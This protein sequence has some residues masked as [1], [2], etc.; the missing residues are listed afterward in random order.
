[1][2][3]SN[4][5]DDRADQASAPT[6]TP[7]STPG[8]D[9][10][11]PTRIVTEAGPADSA[12]QATR[13]A[14]DPAAASSPELGAPGDPGDD[15]H[16]KM[17]GRSLG[18]YRIVAELGVGGMGAVYL[19]EQSVPVH[20]Q[21]ALKVIKAG[22]D[23]AELLQRFR[24]ERDMLARMNHPNIAQVLDV[25]S[26]AGGRLYFAMEYVPGVPLDEFADR[27][28]LD[29][30]HRLELFLQVLEGVQ[31]AH[32][33]GVMHRDLKP[34]NL[35]VADYQGQLLVKVI[36]FGI[37]KGLDAYGRAEAGATTAGLPIGTPNYMSPEQASGDPGAIDTRTDVYS[38]GVVLYKLLTGAL[39]IASSL[40]ARAMHDDLARALREAEIK[41]PSR[42]VM[43]LGRDGATQWKRQ[44]AADH[45]QQARRLRGDLD[46]ITL[47][48][49]E[50]DR[51]RRYASVSEFAAE[52]RR[53][54]NGEPVLAGPPS[55]RYR[56][57]KFIAR[58]RLAVIAA[59][60]VLVALIVGIIGTSW[61]AIEASQQRALAV[62]A[63]HQAEAARDQAKSDRDRAQATRS[64]LEE[65]IAA[66]DPWK[67]RGDSAGARDIRVADALVKAG[68]NLDTGLADNPGLR[69][70]IATL[71]GRTQR[72]LGLLESARTQLQSAVAALAPLYP[73]NAPQRIQA[74][75]EL[76]LTQ[77][78]MG[79]LK[80]AAKT[81]DRL[82]PIIDTVPGLASGSAEELRSE[83]A[84][85]AAQLG[86]TERA[87]RIAR[88]NLAQAIEGSGE[89]S[90]PVS[91]AK[92]ALAEILGSRGA[93]DEAERLL[94]EA[95]N[96]ERNRLGPAHPIVLQLLANA[97]NL[98]YRKG[99]YPLA[100]KR[101]REAAEAA[102]A[103]LG[104]RHP[105][106]LRY[107][108]HVAMT[109]ADSGQYPAALQAFAE[110]IPIRTELLGAEHPDILLMQGNQ[111]LAL[112]A[113]GRLQEANTLMESVYQKRRRVL[114]ETHPE[115]L[116]AL[117]VLGILAREM[118]DLARAEVLLRQASEL[119]AK[120]NG[121]DH[122]ES[123]L[124]Q[125][126]LYSLIIKRGDPERAIAG[127]RE[128]LPRAEKAIVPEHWHLAAIRGNYGEALYRTGRY[129]EAEPLLMASY[130]AVKSQF[131][132]QDPRVQAANRRL[133]ELYKL[134]GR[135]RPADPR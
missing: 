25:G 118:N 83:V 45:S 75:L 124:M 129:A 103:V 94:D 17:I 34:G 96:T 49:L 23:S 18:P 7:T 116:R 102:A 60:A 113:V 114:G 104:P 56:L 76:A 134:W 69:G 58:H 46:W 62:N 11:A 29:L 14:P 98:A 64:F 111:A 6:L 13:A 109:L 5:H 133:D 99:D 40:I 70:E 63:Q 54:L 28:G 47:R 38:L 50:R 22:L 52:L 72:R 79:D 101:Y 26:T 123:L 78:Q 125:N 65:M 30:R 35:L 80:T 27:R 48:A 10:A 68:D 93:W 119:Y 74:E 77:S 31:H 128:L 59:S 87:E 108:A 110:Q 97:A 105:E 84:M 42:K 39:P 12:A 122:P 1:M 132:D 24:S 51:D 57:E 9:S 53:Y 67:L 117:N 85:V 37:A 16:I 106:T 135:A 55:R 33:K 2:S 41:P 112:R 36:D 43:E 89:F 81:L 107:Q 71:L 73:E 19:A 61:M 4:H 8:T 95:Y 88:A 130:R 127:Y 20:R 82:L 44:M 15:T 21:V 126:N 86:D 121:P 66:P 115:T 131:P 91:G 100:E 32:Q 3:S 120:A 90:T 92:A